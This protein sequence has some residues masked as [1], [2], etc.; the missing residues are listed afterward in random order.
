[1]AGWLMSAD[2]AAM[3]W[4]LWGKVMKAQKWASAENNERRHQVLAELGFESIKDVN[5]KG[6]FDRLKKRLLE[7]SDNV[8]NEHEDAGQRRRYLHRIGEQRAE[9]EAMM[10]EEASAYLDRIFKDRWKRISDWN[11]IEDLPTHELEKM[12]MTLDRC[13]KKQRDDRQF[14]REEIAAREHFEDFDVVGPPDR[15]KVEDMQ[16]GNP[17]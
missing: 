15:E 13:L 10:G 8:V 5:M 7:L 1:M 9:L 3:F 11:A 4:R 12:V 16:E 2:Q 14:I 17:F 6:D